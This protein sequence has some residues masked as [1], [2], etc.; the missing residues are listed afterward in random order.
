MSAI[1]EAVAPVLWVRI[2]TKSLG[3]HGA[4]EVFAHFHRDSGSIDQYSFRAPDAELRAMQG[5]A[6]LLQ[7]QTAL[8]GRSQ[9]VQLLVAA[10]ARSS[11]RCV[12]GFQRRNLIAS[13]ER[14]VSPRRC[15]P[16]PPNP[17]RQ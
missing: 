6:S 13:A 4:S 16:A 14:E 12:D 10:P 15:Q 1:E 7:V 2:R 17:H 9:Q 3:G 8:E 11:P 5:L